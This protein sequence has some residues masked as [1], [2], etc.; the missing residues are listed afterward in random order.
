[1][2]RSIIL[3]FLLLGMAPANAVPVTWVLDGV[4]FDDG[5][6]ATGSFV[7]DADTDLYIDVSISSLFYYQVI[8]THYNEVSAWPGELDST[9]LS[10]YTEESEGITSYQD[11]IFLDFDQALSNAGG[12]IG[13][14]GWE[15]SATTVGLSGASSADHYIISGTVVSAVPVPAAVWLFGSALAGLGWMRRKQTV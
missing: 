14:T 6:V 9:T 8:P 2:M 5:G 12:T 1:M 3:M 7:Y 10:L 4:M 15:S 13:V 11:L